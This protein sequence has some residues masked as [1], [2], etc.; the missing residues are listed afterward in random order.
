T[1]ATS[2]IDEAVYQTL[3]EA[4]DGNWKSGTRVL[5]IKEKGV[6]WALDENNRPLLSNEDVNKVGQVMADVAA[7]KI[8][9]PNYL[10]LN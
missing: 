4:E 8:S 10:E 7:G 9:V 3:R 6:G 5:G 1:S 2:Y